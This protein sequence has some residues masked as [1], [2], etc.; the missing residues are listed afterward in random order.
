MYQYD[1][2]LDSKTIFLVTVAEKVV[3]DVAWVVIV[4]IWA[5]VDKRADGTHVKLQ[6]E[7]KVIPPAQE[8][9]FVSATAK[10]DREKTA[11]ES[12][13]QPPA[14]EEACAHAMMGGHA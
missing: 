4:A 7:E 11:G 6:D 1:Q 3:V 8:E 14:Y 13:P 5:A 2:V 10:L 12:K 9:S